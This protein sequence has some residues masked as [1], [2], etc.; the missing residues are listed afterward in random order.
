MLYLFLSKLIIITTTTTIIIIM[1]TIIITT[2]I[3]IMM[4]IITT[5][6]IIM[7]IIQVL[8]RLCVQFVRHFDRGVVLPTGQM[9]CCSGILID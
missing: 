6:I 4:T 9:S 3:I 2:I 8:C 7:I 5:I 1:M